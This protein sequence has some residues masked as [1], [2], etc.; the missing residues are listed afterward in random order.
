MTFWI[1][2]GR[3]Q[4]KICTQLYTP[5]AFTLSDT[6]RAQ[7]AQDLAD[8]LE[9]IYQRKRESNAAIH[10]SSGKE[11]QTYHTDAWIHSDEIDLYSTL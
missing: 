1:D 11:G 10:A 8:E 9:R 3:V 2:C 6:D 4:G 7:V 5:V